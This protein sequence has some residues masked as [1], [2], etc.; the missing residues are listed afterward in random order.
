MNGIDMDFLLKD[1][2]YDVSD[3]AITIFYSSKEP[4]FELSN[5]YAGMPIKIECNGNTYKFNSSEALYQACKYPPE[6]EILPKSS[7][8]TIANVRKRIIKAKTPMQAKMT[9]KC[10]KGFIRK[11]WEDVKIYAMLWVLE[12]KAKRYMRFREVLLNTKNIIV[13]KSKKEPFWGA[14]PD[15]NVLKGKNVLGKLLMFVRDNINDI[16]NKPDGKGYLLGC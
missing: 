8:T 16:K 14:V 4:F 9:Q 3:S 5:M 6:L 10:A 15:G 7:K 13:E 12:L 1:E 11:D 2:V